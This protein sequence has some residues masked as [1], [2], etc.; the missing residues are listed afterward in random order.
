M[1]FI[2]KNPIYPFDIMVSIDETDNEL[3]DKL[4]KSKFK[5]EDLKD[6]LPMQNNVKGRC[7]KTPDNQIIIRLKTL[8]NKP[9]FYGV[10]AHESFHAT[11]FIMS[12]VGIQFDLEYSEEAYTYMLQFIISEIYKKIL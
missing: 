5:Y 9:E 4:T 2:I 11:S 12:M 6:Y 8:P 10:I 3:I 1:N 7:I